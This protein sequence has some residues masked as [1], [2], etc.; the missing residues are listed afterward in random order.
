MCFFSSFSTLFEQSSRITAFIL[1]NLPRSLEGLWDLCY[2]LGFPIKFDNSVNF[3]F[4]IF[5]AFALS[6]K[7]KY[8]NDLPGFYTKTLRNIYLE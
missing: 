7:Y 8:A 4:A 6:L 2:K 1:L 5:M 3:I